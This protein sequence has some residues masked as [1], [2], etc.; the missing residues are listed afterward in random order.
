A[1]SGPVPL[2]SRRPGSPSAGARPGEASQRPRRLTGWTSCSSI[3]PNANVVP[4]STAVSC[5]TVR[6]SP[7]GGQDL[8]ESAGR[9]RVMTVDVAAPAA[10]V[11]ADA[12]G[13][14]FRRRLLDGL[15]ESITERGYRDTTIAHIVRHART[16]KRTF[17]QEFSSK[18]ECF[19]ELLRT[20]N[21]EMIRQIVAAVDP[22]AFWHDQIQQA[23]GAYVDG[24]DP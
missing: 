13:H 1:A 17:Y 9:R 18:E 10:P 14:P 3:T 21:E 6:G 19:I 23:I 12:A 16:S 4:R 11:G 2:R 15:A 20:S 5:S 7:V 24:I 8:S 22:Q